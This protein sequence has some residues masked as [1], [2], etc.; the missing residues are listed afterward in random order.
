MLKNISRLEFLVNNK[1]YHILCDMDSPILDLKEV[2]FQALKYVGQIEDTVKAQQ[3]QK[4]KEEAEKE[5]PKEEA[6][7]EGS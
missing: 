3:E 6:K 2:L 7:P 1:V 4:A 5:P